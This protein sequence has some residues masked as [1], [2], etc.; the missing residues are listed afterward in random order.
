MSSIVDRTLLEADQH[1]VPCC[2][3]KPFLTAGP[4]VMSWCASRTPRGKVPAAHLWL[5]LY[6][7]SIQYKPQSTHSVCWTHLEYKL[8]R[9]TSCVLHF[10]CY[11]LTEHAPLVKRIREHWPRSRNMTEC[12]VSTSCVQCQTCFTGVFSVSRLTH[13]CHNRWAS[14]FISAAVYTSH[15]CSNPRREGLSG[16]LKPWMRTVTMFQDAP[17]FITM[18]CLLGTFTKNLWGS[19]ESFSSQMVES[20]CIRVFYWLRCL[21]SYWFPAHMNEWNQLIIWVFLHFL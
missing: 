8:S 14:N 9:T 18:S 10:C 5:K 11:R 6:M 20:M 13:E 15:M 2:A 3:S 7:K 12:N 19:V 1:A 4:L 16:E 21:T 17:P